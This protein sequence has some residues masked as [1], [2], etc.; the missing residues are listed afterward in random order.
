MEA[1]DLEILSSSRI[2][3]SAVRFEGINVTIYGEGFLQEKPATYSSTPSLSY[4][5]YKID[6]HYF[7]R[8][9]QGGAGRKPALAIIFDH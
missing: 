4:C 1:P 7:N 3:I 8:P 5:N 9:V 2:L 6:N